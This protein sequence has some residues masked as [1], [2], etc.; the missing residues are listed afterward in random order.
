MITLTPRAV[1][2]RRW[3]HLALAG[4]AITLVATPL[5]ADQPTALARA[6]QMGATLWLAAGEGG[7]GGEAGAVSG[8]SE[9]VAYLGRLHIVEGHLRG[10][11]ELYRLGRADEALGVAYHPEAEMMDE[12]R[13][14][15]AAA[16]VAD[17]SAELAAVGA[18]IEAAAPQGDVDAAL[19]ALLVAIRAAERPVAD[20]AR[21]RFDAVAL[22]LRAAAS[23]YAE[24]VADGHIED[25]TPLIEAYGFV[26]TARA[27]LVALAASP[28]KVVADAAA[29][30]NAALTES[31]PLFADLVAPQPGD[32]AILLAIAA[33]IDLAAG[34]VR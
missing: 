5:Y 10:A 32:P 1:R 29:K 28:D 11:A 23:E 33:K 4:A 17:F 3:N 8:A 31:A 27:V 7:E 2:P 13:A 6:Q 9:E 26:E 16:G 21:A 30:A 25:P 18:A 14:A 20:D 22:L 15:L 24:A 34:R 12:V 19:A